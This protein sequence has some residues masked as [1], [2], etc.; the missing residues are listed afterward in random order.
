MPWRCFVVEPSD[1][2]RR[3]LRRYSG[4]E[5][6]AEGHTYHNA[7]V[8]IDDELDAATVDEGGTCEIDDYEDDPRWPKTCDCGYRF[9]PEDHWQVNTTRFYRGCPDGGL[10]VLRELPPGAMWNA[11]WLENLGRGPDGKNWCV[12]MPCGIEWIVYGPSSDGGKWDVQGV[13]PRITVS[14]SINLQGAYHGW[15]KDG[16]ISDDCEGRKFPKHPSTA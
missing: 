8:V 14:P 6:K 12:Q 3:S 2:C 5:C 9:H 7:E 15:I 11:Y 16:V 10:Y 13:P 4:N 1:F